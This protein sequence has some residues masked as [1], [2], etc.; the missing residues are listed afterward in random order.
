MISKT[1]IPF[2]PKKYP[3]ELMEQIEKEAERY[4]KHPHDFSASFELIPDPQG[5]RY[6]HFLISQV[7]YRHGD[8]TATPQ[9]EKKDN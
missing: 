8:L 3:E 4:G 6:G 5:K 2:R 9:G 1:H 7:T